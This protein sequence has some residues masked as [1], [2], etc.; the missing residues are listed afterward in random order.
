MGKKYQEY[1]QLDLTTINKEIFKYWEE[2]N[3]F[4]N[5]LKLRKGS[6]E[7]IFY[8]GPPSANGQP[9]IHH[10]MARAIKDNNLNLM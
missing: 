4:E 9:G 3:I 2:N 5:S 8:E 10:V 7:F 1:K 6:K